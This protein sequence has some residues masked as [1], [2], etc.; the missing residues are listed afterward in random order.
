MPGPPDGEA[1][2]QMQA[3]LQSK[4]GRLFLISGVGLVLLFFGPLLIRRVF[5]N[6]T[7]A[8]IAYVALVV[9]LLCILV[10]MT[11]RWFRGLLTVTDSYLNRDKTKK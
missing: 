6:P 3:A 1:T 9:T 8:N 11:Y 4:R 10:P 5:P 2:P 7:Q